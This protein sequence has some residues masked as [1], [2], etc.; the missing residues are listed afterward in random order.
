MIADER[1]RGRFLT[2]RTNEAARIAEALAARDIIVDHRADRLRLGFGI[3][4]DEAD[5]DRLIDGL[6]A[7]G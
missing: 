3:Y 4:Q 1:R 7:A 6:R 5:V 2:F